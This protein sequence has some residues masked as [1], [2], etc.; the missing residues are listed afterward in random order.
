M[1]LVLKSDKKA[2]ASLGNI[3]GINGSQDWAMFFDFENEIYATKKSGLLKQDYKLE[4][5]VEATRS[6]L[7]GSPITKSNIVTGKQIG[8]AHV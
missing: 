6:S 1:T 7:G 3:N 8:R 5:V 4:D 2:T